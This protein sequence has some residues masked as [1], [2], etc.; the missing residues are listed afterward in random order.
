MLEMC[1]NVINSY[2]VHVVEMQVIKT[3]IS[4]QRMS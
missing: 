1:I 2:E 3:N 4:S